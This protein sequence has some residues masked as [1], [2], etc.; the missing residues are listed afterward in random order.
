[1][2]YPEFPAIDSTIGI[3][4]PSAGIGRKLESFDMSVSALKNMGYSVTE[5]ESV[6][7]DALRPSSGKQRAE[8][9]HSLLI[10]PKVKTIIAASGGEYN[11]EVLPYLDKNLM[12]S[13]P[14]WFCGYSDPTNIMYYM[15]TVMDIATIYG[16]NA[17]AFDW[18]PLHLFQ[19][20]ALEIISGNI[21][22]QESFDMWDS[23]RDWRNVNMNTPVSWDL[24]L[25]NQDAPSLSEQEFKGRLIGGCTDVICKLIGTPYDGTK[26]FL[27]RYKKD[28]FIWYL[29]TYEMS[30]NLLYLTMLQMK[31]A[32]FFTNAKII[33]FGRPMYTANAL[34]EEY[35]ELLK[36]AFN[37]IPFIWG[38][39]IGHTKPVMTI[40]NGSIGTVT[41]NNKRAKLCMELK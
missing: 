24:Y 21:V 20:N 14:K 3:C 41:C 10:N 7:V 30:P 2:I 34:D 37:N 17:G 16:V 28:G 35:I 22:E 29:D 1:M 38:A 4:A 9:F 5:T 36:M 26:D 8:E 40:I 6:R 18:R 33:I 25:P 27:D 15:T 13:N 31:A 11:F 39:D 19:A 32:G 23:E 12:Q